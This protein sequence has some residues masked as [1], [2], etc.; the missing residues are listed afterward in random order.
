M[1]MYIS[2]QQEWSTKRRRAFVV[3]H[4]WHAVVTSKC[5]ESEG[6]LSY[7]GSSDWV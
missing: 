3:R 2:D 1:Y 7:C 6:L 4:C 5:S